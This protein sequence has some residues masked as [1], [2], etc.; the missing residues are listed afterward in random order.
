MA[1]PA[2]RAIFLFG[3]L[4]GVAAITVLTRLAHGAPTAGKPFADAMLVFAIGAALG[5]TS[6][7]LAY[8]SRT[9]RLERLE[10]WTTWRRPLRW[11]AATYIGL[12]QGTPLLMQ[13]FLS[14]Y[15]LAVLTGVRIDPWPAVIVAFTMYAAAFLGEIWRGAIQAIPRQQWEAAA[16]LPLAP[17][18]QLRHVILPQ[19]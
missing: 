19:A 2:V 6:V 18:A 12:I 14:F 17:G 9:F 10:L 3:Y 7:F 16:A 5:L 1:V 15:G 11:L 4:I 8:L 13:L